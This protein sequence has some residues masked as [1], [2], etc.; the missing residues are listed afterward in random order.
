MPQR[1]PVDTAYIGFGN[2]NGFLYDDASTPAISVRT[3]ATGNGAHTIIRFS[4]NSVGTQQFLRLV[5]ELS[6]ATSAVAGVLQNEVEVSLKGSAVALTEFRSLSGAC[7]GS[8]SAQTASDVIEEQQGQIGSVTSITSDTDVTPDVDT[9]IYDGTYI[10]ELGRV[11]RDLYWIGRDDPYY[12]QG[13]VEPLARAFIDIEGRQVELV[14]VLEF[15]QSGG[16]I[17]D[18]FSGS[19]SEDG[20]LSFTANVNYLVGKP[21]PYALTS[22][23]DLEDG[24]ADGDSLVSQPEGFDA[25][26]ESHVSL[27][28]VA[29]P[30][31]ADDEIA[32]SGVTEGLAVEQEE[33]EQRDSEPARTGAYD[34]EYTLLIESVQRDTAWNRND[35]RVGDRRVLANL[36]LQSVDGY[37]TILQASNYMDAGPNFDDFLGEVLSSNR[38]RFLFTTNYLFNKQQTYYL[39]FEL[40]VNEPLLSGEWVELTPDGYDVNNDAVLRL[41]K[42]VDSLIETEEL[43]SEQAE[44]ERRAA[45]Q[46]R[47]AAEQAEHEQ[48]AE[49]HEPVP[50]RGYSTAALAANIEAE[51]E[52]RLATTLENLGLSLGEVQ[53]RNQSAELVEQERLAAEQ[54]EQER[55]AAEAA[56]QER[57]AVEAAEEAERERLAAELAEQESATPQ[58]EGTAQQLDYSTVPREELAELYRNVDA[59]CRGVFE[60][61]PDVSSDA[62]CELRNSIALSLTNSG[63]VFDTQEQEWIGRETHE[64]ANA[65]EQPEQERLAIAEGLIQRWQEANGNCRGGS[66]DS[67]ETLVWCDLRSS[68]DEL[69]ALNDFCY[70]RESEISFEMSWHQCDVDS[71]RLGEEQQVGDKEQAG[72]E[73]ELDSDYDN[74]VA[75][76]EDGDTT[77]GFSCF[78]NQNFLSFTFIT[79]AYI[80]DTAT[81]HL[82][83]I[84]NGERFPWQNSNHGGQAWAG[85]LEDPYDTGHGLYTMWLNFNAATNYNVGWWSTLATKFMESNSVTLNIQGTDYGPFPLKGSARALRNIANLQA[86]EQPHLSDPN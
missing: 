60:S 48:P 40:P 8:P 15:N 4:D 84:F 7:A 46:E 10:I 55:L 31:G 21:A 50:A 13:R 26:Y 12:Q 36:T 17:F 65:A 83:F 49:N 81:P 47:L 85:T 30:A 44:R 57:L 86:C 53:E 68:I 3:E 1:R 37:M 29:S 39:N 52:R 11:W 19:I 6:S 27:F 2:Q 79:D 71:I 42:N 34:G 78:P 23:I 33:R 9:L 24:M 35:G 69:L 61:T 62:A 64:Q 20:N 82:V 63:F 74:K 43:A 56:E 75:T 5:D 45:E 28:K 66:V 73:W 58:S 67:P 70:G 18:D 51:R 25:A 72:Q 38:I 41:R 54:A 32:P 77:I 14:E 76:Y 80:P 22:S 59:H 16:P